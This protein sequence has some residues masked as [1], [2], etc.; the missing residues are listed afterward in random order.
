MKLQL[1]ARNAGPV[2]SDRAPTPASASS[3]AQAF[4]GD[5]GADGGGP[6]A[7]DLEVGFLVATERVGLGFQFR[8]TETS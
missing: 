3:W 2:P 6:R 8:I 1:K 4:Q 7:L 5:S